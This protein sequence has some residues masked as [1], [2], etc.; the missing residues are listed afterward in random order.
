MVKESS[1]TKGL[2]EGVDTVRAEEH[3]VHKIVF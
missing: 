2:L 1:Q 3:E